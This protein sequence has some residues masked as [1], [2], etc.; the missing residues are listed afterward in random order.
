MS[1]RVLRPHD[2]V[3]AALLVLVAF[4]ASAPAVRAQGLALAVNAGISTHDHPQSVADRYRPL[5][6][7]AA[8]NIRTEL[9]VVPLLSSRVREAIDAKSFPFMVVHTHHA[10]LAARSAA[11][12]VLALS[13]DETDDQAFVMVRQDSP[14]RSLRDLSKVKVSF[15]GADSF[16]TAMI[17]AAMREQGVAIDETNVMY[18]RFQ[19]GVPFYVHNGFAEA[20]GTRLKRDATDW[21]TKGGRLL[22]EGPRLP[23]YALIGSTAIDQ[24]T[25]TGMQRTFTELKDLPG[26]RAVLGRL[27]MTGFNRPV[28]EQFFKLA[29][30]FGYGRLPAD[31]ILVQQ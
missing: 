29:D 6:E 25:R 3:L 24:G 28:P 22:Y 1:H 26:G 10:A 17:R 27:K 7:Q 11:Y 21:S 9:R 15:G 8:Q 14:F 31:A 30:W 2:C 18:S 5:S 4:A 13:N 23:V 20:G 19:D 12:Q 16:A